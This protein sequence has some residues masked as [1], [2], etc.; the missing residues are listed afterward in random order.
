MRGP[1][2]GPRRSVSPEPPWA[3]SPACAFQA[4]VHT[5]SVGQPAG[6]AGGD[7]EGTR[8]GRGGSS[9]PQA[10]GGHSLWGIKAI[11]F[12]LPC[13]NEVCPV[14]EDWREVGGFPGRR[15]PAPPGGCCWRGCED[16]RVCGGLETAHRLSQP[17]LLP[18]SAHTVLARMSSA[19]GH[20]V[21]V[22][23]RL[24]SQRVFL[25][26]LLHR[27]TRPDWTHND[28]RDPLPK[29]RGIS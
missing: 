17:H 28:G 6:H 4:C 12:R 23:C 27:R 3:P 22:S 13:W 21:P 14:L 16:P 24:V 5:S 29:S 10:G 11:C 1:W 15:V 19:G 8:R 18:P 26:R 9:S 7:R 25:E 20:L 2:G